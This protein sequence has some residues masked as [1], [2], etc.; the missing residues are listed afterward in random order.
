MVPLAQ[1]NGFKSVRHLLVQ[2]EGENASALTSDE[3]EDKENVSEVNADETEESNIIETKNKQEGMETTDENKESNKNETKNKQEGV[4][5][6]NV[7]GEIQ[8]SNVFN[9]EIKTKGINCKES[10]GTKSEVSNEISDSSY[11]GSSEE[12]IYN[13]NLDSRFDGER[14]D[15]D[16]FK[17]RILPLLT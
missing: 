9:K 17:Q 7:S 5:E 3:D 15:D 14:V 8:S 10:L 6:K 4:F 11:S 2:R 16:W 12:D 13:L 1:A